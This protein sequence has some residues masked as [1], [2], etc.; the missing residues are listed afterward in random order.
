MEERASILSKVFFSWSEKVINIA[1]KN[2]SL[3][4]EETPEPSEKYKMSYILQEMNDLKLPQNSSVL[5]VMKRL[6]LWRYLMIAFNMIISY[7]ILFI[8]PILLK[9]ALDF[10]KD[11]NNRDFNQGIKIASLMF[12][13]NFFRAIYHQHVVQRLEMLMFQVLHVLRAISYRKVLRLSFDNKDLREPGF[14]N[15]IHFVDAD[16]VYTFLNHAHHLFVCPVIIVI[17]VVFIVKQVGYIGFVAPGMFFC[18]LFIQNLIQKRV[19]AT[20]K[21]TLRQFDKRGTLFCEML[22]G[23]KSIRINLWEKFFLNKIFDGRRVEESLLMKYS[24]YVAIDMVV[25]YGV[26]YGITNGMFYYLIGQKTEFSPSQIYAIIVF[27]NNLITP[28]K[29]IA[30][31]FNNLF[32]ANV[33]LKRMQDFLTN[34]IE[35]IDYVEQTIDQGNAIEIENASFDL[36]SRKPKSSVDSVSKEASPLKKQTPYLLSN[37]NLIIKKNEFVAITGPVGSGKSIFLASILG[38]TKKVS[39]AVRVTGKIAYCSQVPVIL[40]ASIKDNI[41]FG[42]D[43][44][45]ERFWR[46]IRLCNLEK[47]IEVF[48]FGVDTMVGD[49]GTTISGGQRQRIALARAIYSDADILIFDDQ[50]SSLDPKVSAEIFA[51]IFLSELYGKKTVICVTSLKDKLPQFDRILNIENGRITEDKINTIDLALFERKISKA[52][53]I[54]SPEVSPTKLRAKKA[55]KDNTEE[56]ILSALKMKYDPV[57]SLQK[58]LI[59]NGVT[60]EVLFL[61]GLF[62]LYQFLKYYSNYWLSTIKAGTKMTWQLVNPEYDRMIIYTMISIFS[63]F[64]IFIQNLQYRKYI[65]GRGDALLKQFL[66]KITM[67]KLPWLLR[68]P[69]GLLTNRGIKD[70]NTIDLELPTNIF[71]SIHFMIKVS[72]ILIINLITSPV[73]VVMLIVLVPVCASAAKR[74]FRSTYSL[75]KLQ[76]TTQ[77]HLFSHVSQTTNGINI[78]RAYKK[79]D[80]FFAE[81][82]K[83]QDHMTTVL[84]HSTFCTR[85]VFVRMNVV[86]SLIVGFISYAAIFSKFM[87]E[88]ADPLIWGISISSSLQIMSLVS[89]GLANLTSCYG[90]L[91]SAQRLQ[92]IVEC[93][94]TEDQKLKTNKIDTEKKQGKPKEIKEGRIHVNNLSFRYSPNLPLVMKNVA[95]DVKPGEHVGVVGR[96]GSGKSSLFLALFNFIQPLEPDSCIQ[97][98]GQNLEDFDSGVLRQNCTFL[99]QEPF[100]F[101]GTLREN[102]DP[103]NVKSNEDIIEAL[104]K[105]KMWEWLE[106]WCE[107]HAS[108]VKGKGPLDL[109]IEGGG[110]NMSIGQRQLLCVARAILNKK[111]VVYLDEITSALDEDSEKVVEEIVEQLFA[112]STILSI[113]HR[114]RSLKNFDK[115][116]VLDAGMV[117]KIDK[118]DVILNDPAYQILE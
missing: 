14:I 49:Q 16:S 97:Y 50:L 51:N 10:I 63:V 116:V 32:S 94:P 114:V 3:T 69:T 13:S 99:A 115:I 18:Q 76:S 24:K 17:S 53:S 46:V 113:S 36:H 74:F 9:D 85:W 23:L 7:L 77:N 19:S 84:M 22:G 47:D 82:E 56:V 117:Q 40:K 108:A 45:E 87:S 83:H 4:I 57:S 1:S 105:V 11:K 44:D 39:G 111:K 15:N 68:C 89:A 64:L 72:I 70:Q 37:V 98:D 91:T 8:G 66:E 92:E 41:V 42:N 52:A 101:D 118:P 93:V 107:S 6:F 80:Q 86:S 27:L 43:Y 90:Q 58:L 2:T 81:F 75:K 25:L 109:V 88:D 38:E 78:I 106:D 103:L 79:E 31:T 12:F 110:A 34:S 104:K 21:S 26:S 67:G 61:L 35:K 20:R 100:L 102:L 55:T 5:Y 33:S 73:F 54:I 28:F 65:F 112:D 71:H 29:Q 30:R 95:F 62:V 59:P 96:T 48:Q 60:L